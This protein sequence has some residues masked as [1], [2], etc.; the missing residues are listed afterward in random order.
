MANGITDNGD[1]TSE[2]A[3]DFPY[4][5]AVIEETITD[6]VAELYINREYGNIEVEV[7]GE[8]V[9]TPFADLTQGQ[10]YTIFKEYFKKVWVPLARNYNRTLATV[11]AA[12][13]A[14]AD[15]D[16]KYM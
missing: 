13:A 7:D 1:G 4:S 9:V 15:S 14:E 12:A 2:I 16:T 10:I 11:P 8:M 5:V 3:M 6:G